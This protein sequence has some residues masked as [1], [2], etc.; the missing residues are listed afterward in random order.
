[1]YALFIAG[2]IV[3]RFYG[4][5][6]YLIIYLLCAAA[7]SVASFVIGG[8]EPS[9]GA[10]GAIFGLFGVLIAAWRVHD[11]TVDSRTRALLVQ[12]MPLVLLNLALGFFSGLPIDNSAHIGGLLAGL[13]LGWLLV[14]GRVG[15][16]ASRMPAGVATRDTWRLSGALRVAG[17]LALVV[18]L[19]VGVAVGTRA[20]GG[21]GPDGIL[22]K[23]TTA[24]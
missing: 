20:R 7:G 12:L 10:S 8:D 13:W 5:A 6:T 17:V 11:P 24:R 16:L 1:M 19:M 21:T 2:P 23:V 14:P 22:A 18:V 9:V 15:T 4:R 3:E